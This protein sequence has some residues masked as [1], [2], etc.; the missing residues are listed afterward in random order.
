MGSSQVRS[1][2]DDLQFD[3][4]SIRGATNDFSESNKLGQGGFG[5]VYRVIQYQNQ[6]NLIGLNT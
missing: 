3:F 2:E 1:A 6:C 5:A 4:G